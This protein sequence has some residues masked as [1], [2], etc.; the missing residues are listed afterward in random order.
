MRSVP[1][2]V[3]CLLGMDDTRF[4][5]SSRDDGDDLLLRNFEGG[6]YRYT[7]PGDTLGADRVVPAELRRPS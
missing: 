1:Y 3:V 4:P 6:V 2:R 7:D 5:R